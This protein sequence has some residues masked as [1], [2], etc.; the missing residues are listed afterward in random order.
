MHNN[1]QNIYMLL[2]YP[3]TQFLTKWNEKKKKTLIFQTKNLFDCQS[4]CEKQMKILINDT[5]FDNLICMAQISF[6]FC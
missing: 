4:E 5:P 2:T 1:K 3:M 6:Y